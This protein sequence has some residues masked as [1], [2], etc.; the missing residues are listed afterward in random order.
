MW[1]EVRTGHSIRTMEQYFARDYTGGAFQLLGP[2]HLVVLGIIIVLNTALVSFFRFHPNERIRRYF[3]YGLAT[4]LLLNEA[5]WQLW[6]LLT[7][8]WVLQT[9][10]PLHLCAFMAYIS[11]IILITKSKT[12]YEFGYFLGL[13]GATQALLTP[14]AGIYGFPHFR[15][16]QTFI[17][18]GGI[19][20][21][22][23]YM[24]LV[25]R[26]RPHWKTFPRLIVGLNVYMI[27]VGIVNAVLGSN[28][29]FIVRKPD[30]P[31][32]LDL[33][34]PWPWYILWMEAGGLL[35]CLLLYLPFA[36]K[37]AITKSQPQNR[38]G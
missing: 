24:T 30:I 27:F 12:L 10:L 31:T 14:D 4:V 9:M 1:N 17:N 25:E 5:S 3:R 11:A 7:G 32:L 29:L 22:V 33:M 2:P 23:L 13:G 34:P 28:Y 37:D 20:T 36:I 38:E 6:N 19:V 8:G 18:H 26:Y 21:A 35:I 16:I 15:F